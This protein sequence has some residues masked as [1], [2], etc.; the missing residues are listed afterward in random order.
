MHFIIKRYI[1]WIGIL[2][3]FCSCGT[4]GRLNA[5]PISKDIEL[6]KQIEYEIRR[7]PKQ[8]PILRNPLEIKMYIESVGNNILASSEIKYRNQFAYQFEIIKDDTTVNAFCT[9]GGYIYVYTGLLKFIE[10]EASLAGILAHEIA[11]AERRHSTNK[12]SAQYGLQTIIG[13]ASNKI[14][15]A[16]TQKAQVAAGIGLLQYSRDEEDEADMYSLD[17]K[18]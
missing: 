3:L 13:I 10:D 6:C 8:Y 12:I 17:C 5:F 18:K 16:G 1:L 9:P 2:G 14:G 4:L 11:H 7:N 15:T